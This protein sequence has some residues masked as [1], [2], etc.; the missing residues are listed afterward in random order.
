MEWYKS[1]MQ[2]WIL[3]VI[4]C[5]IMKIFDVLTSPMFQRTVQLRDQIQP[6]QI[7][8]SQTTGGLK[9]QNQGH[10]QLLL[11]DWRIGHLNQLQTWPNLLLIVAKKVVA[12]GISRNF[13]QKQNIK[14]MHICWTRWRNMS[15][16]QVPSR[17]SFGGSTICHSRLLHRR[18]CVVCLNKIKHDMGKSTIT[19]LSEYTKNLNLHV[20][21]QY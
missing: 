11:N 2:H 9:P 18:C 13:L 21:L 1:M 19:K 20:P 5:Y 10:S 15:C 16:F 6:T 12:K 17:V 7:S 4:W 14:I 8:R 3:W